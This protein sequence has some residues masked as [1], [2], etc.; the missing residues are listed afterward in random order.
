VVRQV[1]CQNEEEA[2]E[3][4]TAGAHIV[5]LDN[6]SPENIAT[7]S[8]RIKEQFPHVLIEA[9]GVSLMHSRYFASRV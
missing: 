5:M 7:A 2:V 4:A 9:S 1:E 6:F 8:R 3:A